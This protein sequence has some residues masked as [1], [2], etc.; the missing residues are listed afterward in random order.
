[1]IKAELWAIRYALKLCK[2]RNWIS[3]LVE[4][5]SQSA[6]NLINGEEDVDI[7]QDRI[8][9]EDC[10]R[11]IRDMNTSVLH[12]LREANKFS[13]KLAKIGGKQ[14]EQAVRM[15][16]PT[17]DIIEDLKADIQGTA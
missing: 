7:H 12:V 16:I 5:D 11:L 6:V 3:V 4:S 1:M 17:E 13:D 15:L 14:G 9:I 2:D 10:R 8:L